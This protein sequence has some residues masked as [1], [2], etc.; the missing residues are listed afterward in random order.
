[1]RSR[2][3]VRLTTQLWYSEPEQIERSLRYQRE[4]LARTDLDERKLSA[5][6]LTAPQ[7]HPR[8]PLSHAGALH[9]HSIAGE[10]HRERGFGAFS[11]SSNLCVFRCFTLVPPRFPCPTSF[12]LCVFV[13]PC[14]CLIALCLLPLFRSPPSWC[15]HVECRS[16]IALTSS[17]SS[18]T[19]TPAEVSAPTRSLG[20]PLSL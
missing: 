3:R 4:L 7:L 8:G 19:R 11:S 12:H 16:T 17:G 18:T 6:L 1:M 5:A 13:R 9:L 20:G 2:V 10:P 14:V 15:I